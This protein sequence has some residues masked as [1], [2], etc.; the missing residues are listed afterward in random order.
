MARAL[1]ILMMVLVHITGWGDTYPQ[2]KLGI[3]SFMMPA[4]L[5]LTG[6][7][8]NADKDARTFLRYLRGIVVPYVVLVSGFAVLSCFL[9]VRGGIG[10]LTAGAVA[11]TV[12]VTSIGPYW[13][14]RNMFFCSAIWYVIRRFAPQKIRM[15]G[16]LMIYAAAL[17]L[18][19]YAMPY[20]MT[21]ASAFYYY[22]GVVARESFTRYDRIIVASGWSVWPLALIVCFPASWDWMLISVPVMAYLFLSF[23]AWLHDNLGQGKAISALLY[24]GMNTLPVYLLHPIFTMAAKYYAPLFAADTTELSFTAVTLAVSAAGSIALAWTMDRCRLSWILGRKQL[25][26]PGSPKAKAA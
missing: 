22:I 21:T 11:R 5:F 6:F 3:L 14:L 9:P 18:L 7:L 25:L 2:I 23:S 10:T 19:T 4:F 15:P 26:R 24:L 1:L 13:F 12:L 16:R 20:E 8:L 17:L